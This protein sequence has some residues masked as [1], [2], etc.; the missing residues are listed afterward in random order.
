ME[1]GLA[2]ASVKDKI[3]GLEVLDA[4]IDEELE[5]ELN[6]VDAKQVEYTLTFKSKRGLFHEN[7]QLL[8]IKLT[9]RLLLSRTVF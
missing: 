4:N 6:T 8:L 2:P 1:V 9:K 7:I 3:E 5:V